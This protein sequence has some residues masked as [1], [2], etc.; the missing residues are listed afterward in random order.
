MGEANP[1][2]VKAAV[3]SVLFCVVG[4]MLVLASLLPLDSFASRSNW[5]MED[6]D[7]YDRITE[8]YKDSTYKSPGELGLTQEQYDQ[9]QK[10][11]LTAVEAMRDK[12]EYARGRGSVWK[13]RLRWSGI[14]TTAVGLI[15]H[16]YAHRR[17]A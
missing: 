3:L 8:E 17:R 10:E 5:S 2:P 14:A 7:S 4:A 11:L 9:R 13:Q 12:L 15:L 1:I 16:L 6:S